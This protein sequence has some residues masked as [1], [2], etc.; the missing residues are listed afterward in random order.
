MESQTKLNHRLTGT[1]NRLVVGGV[2][3][4]GKGVKRF[5]KTKGAAERLWE[6]GHS[7]RY[8]AQLWAAGVSGASPGAGSLDGPRV[9]PLEG[10]SWLLTTFWG[11]MVP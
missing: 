8:G 4:W 9:Q 6:G 1:E 5:R 3:G 2:E 11:M 10:I 7:Q